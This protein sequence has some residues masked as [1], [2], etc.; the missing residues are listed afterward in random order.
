LDGIVDTSIII[1]IY[2]GFSPAVEWR[3]ANM[4]KIFGITPVVWM[5]VV[6]GAPNKDKQQQMLKI[7]SV[8]QLVFTTEADQTWA[9]RQL[10]TY[11][12]SHSI[13]LTDAL[14]G[15]PAYRLQKALYTRNS[16]H[17]IPMIPTLVQESY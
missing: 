16:K 6:Q 12:L 11:S 4:E 3:N 9:M 14:I 15:A 13:D 2:R 10:Q 7:L 8:F 17:F 5:E 1:D